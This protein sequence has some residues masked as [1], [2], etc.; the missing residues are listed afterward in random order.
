MIWIIFLMGIANIF[1]HRTVME[2]RGPVFAELADVLRRIGGGWGSYALEFGLLV[3][4]LWFARQGQSIALIVY[5]L[6]TAINVGA[7]VMLR[8]LNER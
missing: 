5:G 6:Y 4:A 7:Y 8:R 3:A 2:G 1:L